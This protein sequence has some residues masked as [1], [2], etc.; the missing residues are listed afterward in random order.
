MFNI[1]TLRSAEDVKENMFKLSLS[2]GV[3]LFKVTDRL[4]LDTSQPLLM[5]GYLC[6]LYCMQIEVVTSLEFYMKSTDMDDI[7]VLSFVIT[8]DDPSEVSMTI[9]NKTLVRKL[10][11]IVDVLAELNKYFKALMNSETIH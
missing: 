8:H 11:G 3:D 1:A 2:P 5:R 4:G 7:P 10:G 6:S 9:R